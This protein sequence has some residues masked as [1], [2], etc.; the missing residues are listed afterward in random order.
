[1]RA[2]L[3][4]L[5][6][7]PVGLVLIAC[8]SQAAGT[9]PPT[10]NEDLLSGDEMVDLCVNLHTNAA[11]YPDELTRMNLDLRAKYSPQ[12]AQML[13]DPEL[14][15][16][17]EATGVAETAADAASARERCTA[18]AKP[19]WGKPQPRNDV[20]RLE[21]CYALASCDAEMACIQPI[22]EP[23]FAYRAAHGQ[24]H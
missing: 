7:V 1:M 8:H 15:K 11:K 18:F 22:V 23:R 6:V 14:R 21:G 16:Q 4:V 20:S 19:E 2:I 12:F 13:R 24:P 9:A 3:D 5:R 17:A 10:I